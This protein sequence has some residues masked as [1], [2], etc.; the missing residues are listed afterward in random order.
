MIKIA[1]V[2]DICSGKTYISKLFKEPVFS[3]DYEVAKIYQKNKK[4]FKKLRKKFPEFIRRLPIE[5][6]NII[7]LLLSNKRNFKYLGKIVHPFVRQK[8]KKF[9]SKNKKKKIVILDIPLFLENKMYGKNDIIIFVKTKKSDVNKKIKLR[10][11]FNKI[12]LKKFKSLQLTLSQKRKR[13]HFVI[14]N[15]FKSEIVKKSV[16]ILKRKILNDRNCA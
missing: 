3:A 6:K 12:L 2:G 14:N 5:K 15:N 10:P 1:L 13:S 11:N 7:S 8:L 4:C 9:F 16:K